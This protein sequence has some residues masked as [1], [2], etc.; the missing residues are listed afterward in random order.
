MNGPL[1]GAIAGA[2]RPGDPHGGPTVRAADA[3][4]ASTPA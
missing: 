2:T 3:P 4:L 1:D